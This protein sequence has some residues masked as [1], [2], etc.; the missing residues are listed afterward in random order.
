MFCK[1]LII[2]MLHIFLLVSYSVDSQPFCAFVTHFVRENPA[3]R[4]QG[5]ANL[6][7]IK[8][9]RSIN[10]RY[11]LSF[12]KDRRIE[13]K[14]YTNLKPLFSFPLLLLSVP[15]NLGMTWVAWN[16]KIEWL[17]SFLTLPNGIPSH[18]I[19]QVL[20]CNGPS[21]VSAIF[22]AL[23]ESLAQNY[24]GNIVAIYAMGCQKKIA[25]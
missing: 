23:A 12:M 25:K 6:R 13:R 15:M 18:D 7:E 22:T 10:L 4:G 1:I 17:T 21:K 2:N 19:Q 16:T 8:S 24:P 5:F 3:C 20:C 11:Y 9:Y 14:G